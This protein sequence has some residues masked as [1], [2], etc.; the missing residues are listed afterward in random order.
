M[1]AFRHSYTVENNKLI[2]DLPT[3][4]K[5]TEVDV[6]VLPSQKQD[7]HDDL[8]S[9][10]LASIDRGLEDLKNGRTHTDEEV[11]KGVRE[12]ILNAQNG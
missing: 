1:E 5:A 10:Q 7:W 11:R 12:R 2:I 4:F 8:T 9:E 3:D 6:I